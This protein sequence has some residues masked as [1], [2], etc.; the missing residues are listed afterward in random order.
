[1]DRVIAQFHL[2]TKCTYIVHLLNATNYT[3]VIYR[4]NTTLRMYTCK[5]HCIHIG[6][7]LIS[8]VSYTPVIWR[9]FL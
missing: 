5:R 9:G 4:G 6:H 2:G 3:Y 1:M 7:E 8:T